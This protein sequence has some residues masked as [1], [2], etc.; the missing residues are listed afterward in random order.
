MADDEG[1]IKRVNGR[2]GT[3]L[4]RRRFAGG[5]REAGQTDARRKS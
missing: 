2:L 3:S 4:T 1:E 5:W